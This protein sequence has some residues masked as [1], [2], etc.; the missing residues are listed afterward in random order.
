MINLISTENL[1][2]NL[3]KELHSEVKTVVLVDNKD[4]GYY[5]NFTGGIKTISELNKYLKRIYPGFSL[6]KAEESGIITIPSKTGKSKSTKL[7]ISELIFPEADEEVL[8]DEI[9]F[10]A[11]QV[12][13]EEIKVIKITKERKKRVSKKEIVV[14]ES[15]KIN[16]EIT[17]ISKDKY[18]SGKYV[19]Y[20][21]MKCSAC[22]YT[23]RWN[24]P[25]SIERIVKNHPA[26]CGK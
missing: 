16:D 3:I 25:V 1:I 15:E 7:F 19:K 24:L 26:K 4:E 18:K 23:S 6:S 14:Y 8:K 2:T 11:D 22:L 9:T 12:M 5:I 10:T 13:E 20:Q 17:V 21:Q